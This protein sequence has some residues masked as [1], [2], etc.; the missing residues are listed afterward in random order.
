MA[1][2]WEPG[3]RT[4]LTYWMWLISGNMVQRADNSLAMVRQ[5]EL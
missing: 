5:L 3:L 2:T 4:D 1:M